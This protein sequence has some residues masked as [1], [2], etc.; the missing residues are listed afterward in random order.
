MGYVAGVIAGGAG[1]EGL[2]FLPGVSGPGGGRQQA[3]EIVGA[4]AGCHVSSMGCFMGAV[5]SAWLS[6]GRVAIWNTPA[7]SRP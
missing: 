2:A 5:P 1:A 6:S 4:R 3:G 7:S